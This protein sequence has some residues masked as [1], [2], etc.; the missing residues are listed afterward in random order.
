MNMKRHM[1]TRLVGMS[2][3]E[4]VNKVGGD[5]TTGTIGPQVAEDPALERLYEIQSRVFLHECIK[6]AA[7]SVADI[8][9]H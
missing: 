1:G 4:L 6:F 8:V 5:Q 2:N 7:L 3:E 9:N